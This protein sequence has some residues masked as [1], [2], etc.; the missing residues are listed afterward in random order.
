M[1]TIV[2][3]NSG[4]IPLYQQLYEYIKEEIRSGRLTE[5]EKLP[6]SRVLAEHLKISRGTVDQAFAQLAEE[7]YIRSRDRSGFYVLR[8]ERRFAGGVSPNLRHDGDD[9]PAEQRAPRYRYDLRSSGVDTEHFP[10][11]VWSRLLRNVL[12]EK[13]GELLKAS[14][15]QGELVLR[16]QLCRYLYQYRRVHALPEQIVVGAGTEYLLGLLIQL[17]GTETVFAVEDPGYPR[18]NQILRNAGMQPRRIP[19]D[20]EGIRVDLLEASG[21]DAVHVTP[22]HQFPTGVVLSAGRREQLLS[23]ASA[24][25]NRFILEDD[26]VSEF[27]FSGRPVPALQGMGD[28]EK[29]VYFY[30]FAQSLAPSLRMAYMVLPIRLL[31]RW[32]E[33]FSGYAC[34]VPVFEQ[35]TL[36]R[37]MQEGYYE[38][39]LNRM[40]NLYKSRQ[41]ALAGVLQVPG[42]TLGAME[43]GL[44]L[45]LSVDSLTLTG[46]PADTAQLTQLAEEAGIHLTDLSRY[47][48]SEE[49][50]PPRY[51]AGYGAYDEETLREAGRALLRAWRMNKP[52]IN[53]EKDVL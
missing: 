26:Y 17:L 23:W 43:G 3:D 7:G 13:G 15:P 19:V 50:K 48:H 47:D 21:A 10:F 6:S 30:T 18:L 41:Q 36:A 44:A 46:A 38:R 14:P 31:Q 53:E 33:R 52:S 9:P 35:L 29:I 20:G 4:R 24:A 34:S 51:L 12:T 25:D 8:A 2:L 37:F 27:R 40:K 39:H 1:I 32:R 16:E 42:I 22:G 45:M 49:P 5:G 11:S 28:P